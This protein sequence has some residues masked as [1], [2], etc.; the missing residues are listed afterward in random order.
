MINHRSPWVYAI[1][2]F[3][4]LELGLIGCSQPSDNSTGLNE[5][6]ISNQNLEDSNIE[7]AQAQSPS[8]VG[9]S[10]FST[11]TVKWAKGRILLHPSAG[12]S[13][14]QVAQILSAHGGK[15]ISKIAQINVHIVELP[16]NV[17]EKRWNEEWKSDSLA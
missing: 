11:D 3:I 13:D 12:V 1:L 9:V 6:S 14:L 15:T 10:S 16:A 17:N 2:L 5:D 7:K 4:S 8:V